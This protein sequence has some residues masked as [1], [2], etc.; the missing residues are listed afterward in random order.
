MSPRKK[1]LEEAPL[2]SAHRASS[3]TGGLSGVF[4]KKAQ[5]K[6]RGFRGVFKRVGL[7]PD[8]FHRLL[9]GSEP[10][11]SAGG[12]A[13]AEEARKPVQRVSSNERARRVWQAVVQ[14][15]LNTI[16]LVLKPVVVARL[17]GVSPAQVTRWRQDQ[18]PDAET[19]DR[20]RR[21][22]DTVSLLL[23]RYQPGVAAD[24]LQAPN[25]HEMDGGGTPADLIRQRKW[26]VLRAYAEEAASEGYG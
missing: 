2:P 18:L 22:A 24:W 19:R 10:G 11:A 12:A 26:D 16:L 25:I 6:R 8:T 14:N 15:Q 13:A 4:R 5:L 7:G 9:E 20:L 1:D 23:Q 21:L 3:Q 17:L